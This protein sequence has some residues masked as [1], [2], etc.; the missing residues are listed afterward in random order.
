MTNIS[1]SYALVIVTVS[2]TLVTLIMALGRNERHL[3]IYTGGFAFSAAC[4]FLYP[5]QELGFSFLGIVLPNAFLIAFH[6]FMVWGIRTFYAVKPTMA[7]R[8]IAYTVIYLAAMVLLT[9]TFP[10]F[11][12]R[13]ILTS[14]AIILFVTEFLRVLAMYSYGTV[15]AIRIPVFAV[16]LVFVAFHAARLVMTACGMFPA[17]ELLREN[18]LTTVLMGFTLFI[19]ILWSGCILLL[20]NANLVSDL[21][22]KNAML[23]NLALKDELTG[24]FNRHSLDQTIVAEMQR[25]NRYQEPVSLIMLD[26][27]HFKDVNDRFGHD[28]GDA[29][30]VEAARRVLKGIRST[31]FLFRWGGEEFLILMP[32]TNLEGATLVADKLRC[33]LLGSPIEPVGTITAS[34]GVAERVPGE[35]REDWFRH[36]DQAMYRAK[37]GGRNRVEAWKPGNEMP[38]ATLRVEW[39]K[40]WNSGN[41]TIDRQHQ[42]IIALGNS[43]LG[44]AVSK[45]KQAGIRKAIETLIVAIQNHFAEEES[46]IRESGF[47]DTEHHCQIHRN[48]YAEAREMQESFLK[49]KTEPTIL[50]DYIVHKIIL[51]HILTTDIL[52]YPYMRER[53]RKTARAQEIPGRQ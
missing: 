28:A 45:G 23:E 8:F 31:D 18:P 33:A 34:F 9:Y 36:V 11:K 30:L 20:D 26:L 22:K 6:L 7:R 44:L 16:F 52:Y 17:H 12:W 35:S 38:V 19:S 21:I 27:D 39:Q 46:I 53:T 10:V 5:L 47:P 3:W 2:L 41:Q 49:G 1:L 48:L 25:Q 43:L 14:A 40:E 32:N 15:N 50:F 51:D 29:I 13:A 37:R 4:F 24:L 42:E